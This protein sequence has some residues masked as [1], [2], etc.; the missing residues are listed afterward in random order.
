M[1]VILAFG[2]IIVLLIVLG[3]GL[4][5]GLSVGLIL[6]GCVL[7]MIWRQRVKQFIALAS[8]HN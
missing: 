5:I 7:L 2:L 4:W 6:I 8:P 1:E 3:S